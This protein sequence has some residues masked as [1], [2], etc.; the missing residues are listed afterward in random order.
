MI[1]DY[2]VCVSSIVTLI[3]VIIIAS[4]ISI[5]QGC[6]VAPR[7]EVYCVKNGDW[8]KCPKGTPAGTILDKGGANAKK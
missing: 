8:V 3:L 2:L 7:S 5:S 1:K 6:S 4:V